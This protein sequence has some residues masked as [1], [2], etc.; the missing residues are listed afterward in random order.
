MLRDLQFA[1]RLWRKTPSAFVL[2]LVALG[3]G[4]GATTAVFSV[5]RAVLFKPLP[6]PAPDELVMV[7]EAN[8]PRSLDRNVVSPGNFIHWRDSPLAFNE[9]RADVTSVQVL[10]AYSVCEETGRRPCDTKSVRHR[11]TV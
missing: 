5:V 9:C 7:W 8:I 11:Q 2:A 10:R 3:L 1:L 4:S 6:Y